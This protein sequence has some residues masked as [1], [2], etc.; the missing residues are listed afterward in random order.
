M[1]TTQFPQCHPQKKQNLS[2][3]T[4]EEKG[5]SKRGQQVFRFGVCEILQTKVVFIFLLHEFLQEYRWFRP[6]YRWQQCCDHVTA[7]EVLSG[8]LGPSHSSQENQNS[9]CRRRVYA[10]IFQKCLERFDI[11]QEKEKKKTKPPAPQKTDRMR[12]SGQFFPLRYRKSDSCRS[13]G[14]WRFTVLKS[15]GRTRPPKRIWAG[16]LKP[17]RAITV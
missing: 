5:F 10:V 17:E 16:T 1:T 14:G 2:E 13:P 15:P 4:H 11:K 9:S 3:R 6:N 8:G 7:R 12:L